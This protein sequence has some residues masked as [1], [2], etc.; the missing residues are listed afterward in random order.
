MAH[1]PA[2]PEP[3]VKLVMQPCEAM[4]FRDSSWGVRLEPATMTNGINILIC[5]SEDYPSF[6]VT[7][8]APFLSFGI[9]GR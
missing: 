2:T 4:I 7:A 6:A 9:I 1:T 8:I 5:E 3:W